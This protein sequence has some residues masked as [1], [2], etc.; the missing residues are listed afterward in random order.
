M[1]SIIQSY[2]TDTTLKLDLT[3]LFC[4]LKYNAIQD[5]MISGI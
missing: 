3:S 5:N 4:V 2:Q 1:I